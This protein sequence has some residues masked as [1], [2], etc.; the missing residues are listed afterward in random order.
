METVTEAPIRKPAAAP[1]HEAPKPPK[2]PASPTKKI[3][4][5]LGVLLVL[6]VVVALVFGGGNDG[7]GVEVETAVATVRPVT[8]TVTASGQ[9]RPEV[10]V[11]ISSDVSGEIVF[12]GVEEGDFVARGQLLLRVQPDFYASQREQAEAG[13]LQAQAGVEQARA[14]IGRAQ[15]ELRRA[16]TEMART[17]QLVERG[18]A[19]S[20]ELDAARATV[21]NARAA[22]G[23][24]QA[25]ERAA[26]FSVRSAQATLRQASQQLGKTSIYAPIAG[27]VSQLD[28]ELGERVVGTAQMAGTEIMR[29]AE[30]DRMQLEV[31]VNENDVVHI[32]L[33]DSARIEVDAYPDR[34]LGGTVTQIANSARVSALGTTEQVTNFPIEVRI[35]GVGGDSTTAALV[36]TTAEES[37]GASSAPPRLRPGMS[38]TVDVFTRTVQSAV[39]VPIQAVTIRDFNALRREERRQAREEDESVDEAPIPDEEDLRRVVF[40]VEDGKAVM[41]EVETGIQDDTHIEVVSGLSGGETV[42][43]GPFRL[44]RTD[45]EDGAPVRPRDPDA[46]P[47]GEDEE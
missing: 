18:A 40:V 6:L 21:E 7:E 3:L 23:I 34:P 13:V 26:G 29:I 46:E 2:A 42:V 10:E 12:L 47:L 44:L 31:D 30:L 17:Q 28:V 1:T 14:D 32:Q 15:A 9:I 24:A 19:G 8:Q 27:T 25:A 4:L 11:V 36:A 37:P 45:L 33:G 16:E 20:A 5:G 22:V 39:V 43:A 35:L 41:R 38:G